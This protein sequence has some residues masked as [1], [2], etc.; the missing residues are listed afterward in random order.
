VG[1][2]RNRVGARAG[3]A[4]LGEFGDRGAQDGGTAFFRMTSG[5]HANDWLV[6]DVTIESAVCLRFRGDRP[7]LLGTEGG[8]HT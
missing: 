7:S 5:A 1:G 2:A 8:F 6:L 3:N 4:M